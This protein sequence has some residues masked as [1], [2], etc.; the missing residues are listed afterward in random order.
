[1]SKILRSLLTVTAGL[2]LAIPG[3]AQDQ[4]GELRFVETNGIRMA[5][6]V[7]GQGEPLLFLHGFME[8][9]ASWDP[10]LQD[11][12]ADYMVILPQL[13]GHGQ[14]TNPT[15]EFT[16]REAARDI[17]G[18]LDELD[19]EKVRAAG[20]STGGMTLLHMAT[21]Q[22]ERIS[23]MALL[24]ATTYFP[25]QARAVLRS[26]SLETMPPGYTEELVRRHGDMERVGTLM[27]QFQGFQDS[28]DDMDFTPPLLATITART[29]IAHGDRDMFFPVSIATEMHYAIPQ[30][31]LMIHPNRGHAAIPSDPEGRLYLVATLRRFFAGDWPCDSGCAMR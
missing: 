18:L 27:Q 24:G 19:I 6:R 12:S 4:G 9:D 17:F 13:R 10:I 7:V 11:F 15:G 21:Q 3:G 8:T 29:L 16:H 31:Y 22:P 14:S 26:T 5:Y 30:S 20:A 2:A 28:Y 1:M 23:A 25:A